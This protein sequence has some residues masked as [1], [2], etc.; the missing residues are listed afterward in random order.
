MSGGMSADES[1]MGGRG[2]RIPRWTRPRGGL[3]CQA[4]SSLDGTSLLD[5]F[6]GEFTPGGNAVLSGVVWTV[7]V[8]ARGTR[9][10][11]G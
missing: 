4:V 11:C 6:S 2:C 10:A 9:R 8:A 1:L 7:A 3:G 5:G